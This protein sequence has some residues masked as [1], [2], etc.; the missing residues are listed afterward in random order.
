LVKKLHFLFELWV[1]KFQTMWTNG[2]LTQSQW[3]SK[4]DVT[5]QDELIWQPEFIYCVYHQNPCE[6]MSVVSD[7]DESQ[8]KRAS[9]RGNNEKKNEANSRRKP[10]GDIARD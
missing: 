9:K 4:F 3:T 7:C 2:E 6:D 8:I 5:T 10:L 1:S